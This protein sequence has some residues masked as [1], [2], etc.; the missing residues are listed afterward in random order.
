MRDFLKVGKDRKR[1]QKWLDRTGFSSK[2]EPPER[3][4][5]VDLPGLEPGDF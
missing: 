3:W 5:H 1:N 2:K 4:L